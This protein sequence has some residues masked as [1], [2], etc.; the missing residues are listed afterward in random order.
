MIIVR[1]MAVAF[2][3]VAASSLL[4]RSPTRRGGPVPFFSQ[5][6]VVSTSVVE[7]FEV[8]PRPPTTRVRRGEWSCGSA[9]AAHPRRAVKIVDPAAKD[10]VWR[11]RTSVVFNSSSLSG[12]R[13]RGSNRSAG[14]RHNLS[15]PGTS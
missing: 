3:V 11:E 9:N 6:A 13:S 12:H 8:R 1:N 15:V 5:P 10:I 14:R 2:A 7:K 4:E